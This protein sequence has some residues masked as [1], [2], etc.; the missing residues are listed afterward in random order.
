[1]RHPLKRTGD[2]VFRVDRGT[3]LAAATIA[4][5]VFADS[6]AAQESP[7]PESGT[8]NV[9]F[10]FPDAG[11]TSF[12]LTRMVGTGWSVG[13]EVDFRSSDT[14]VAPTEG[15]VAASSEVDDRQFLI[16]PVIKKYLRHRGPVAPFIRTSFGA[17]WTNNTTRQTNATRQFDTFTFS[18]RAGVGA[19][20]FPV[21][22]ISLGGFT[23]LLLNRTDATNTLND[24][25]LTQD[26]WAVTTFRSNL[27]LRIWF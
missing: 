22:G 21:D 20:W 24:V 11:G 1:M 10:S 7:V 18:V 25:G 9:S 19:D 17:G 8:W 6:A 3:T 4:A 15:S 2:Q 27:V 26:S 12:G 5:L 16:G 14:D 23:G 13:L